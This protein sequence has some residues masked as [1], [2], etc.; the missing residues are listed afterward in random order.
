MRRQERIAFTSILLFC[1]L[2]EQ[3]ISREKKS[4]A[5]I[6]P[7]LNWMTAEWKS[8]K[9]VIRDAILNIARGK[10][11][12]DLP[13]LTE[14]DEEINFDDT[15]RNLFFDTLDKIFSRMRAGVVAKAAEIQKQ[16]KIDA[17][18]LIRSGQVN[19]VSVLLS[20]DGLQEVI[21][22]LQWQRDFV[23]DFR[24]STGERISR[25]L[26]SRYGTVADLKAQVDHA[27]RIGRDDLID[28]FKEET[29]G[30]AQRLKDGKI[31]SESFHN[32]MMRSIDQHYRK[33]YRDGK[34][35]PLTDSDREFI[36]QQVESQRQYLDNFKIY[37]DQKKIIGEELDGRIPVRASLYGERGSALY[38]AGWIAS[39]PDD[40][41]INWIL[42]PAEHCRD[43]P[44]IAAHSPY[45]K[46]TLPGFPGEGFTECLTN[47]QC[48][49][50]D[51]QP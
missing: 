21:A 36:R 4:D 40:A 47:C 37:I 44:R 9:L 2:L 50:E 34:G 13:L 46:A 22:G 33:L 16:A 48:I 27:L 6:Q 49:L 10:Q 3:T 14:A 31:S 38:E 45:T 5:Y 20:Q 11:P 30:I 42:Q 28:M 51:W 24:L 7:F 17:N 19:V 12:G 1:E 39:L 15:Q 8:M 35:L 23:D 43:C 18:P 29:R 32:Q 25:L 26:D 41:L